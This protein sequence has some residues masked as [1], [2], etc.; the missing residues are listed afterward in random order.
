LQLQG[1]VATHVRCGWLL[2][3][4]ITLNLS[5]SLVVKKN[6]KIGEQHLAKLQAKRLIVS[7]RLFM[8]K[9]ELAR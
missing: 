6:L 4:D 3:Y 2:S 8:L 9:D 1:S 5:L 7:R